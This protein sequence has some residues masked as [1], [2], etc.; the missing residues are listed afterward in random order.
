MRLRHNSLIVCLPHVCLSYLQEAQ[1]QQ[2]PPLPQLAQLAR[3]TAHLGY[4]AHKLQGST[5][6]GQMSV[7][8]TEASSRPGLCLSE[9]DQVALQAQTLQTAMVRGASI[10]G[11]GC[12]AW[13][14]LS[15]AGPKASQSTRQC[16]Q[17]VASDAA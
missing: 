5:S 16:C 6:A 12:A 3:H 1:Q 13:L 9:R 11:D 10:L 8:H 14:R 2:P 15:D 17:Q 4:Q 7:L